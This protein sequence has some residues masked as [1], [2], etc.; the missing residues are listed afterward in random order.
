[1]KDKK[2][3]Q[4]TKLRDAKF[5]L[6]NLCKVKRK[7]PPGLIPFVLRECQK[8]LFNAIKVYSRI[9]IL[10]VRQL[11]FSTAVTGYFYHD[12]IMNPGTTTALIGYNTDM[13]AE[14]LDKVKTFYR[15]TPDDLKPTIHYNSKY[16]I[17]FPRIDSKILVLPSTESVGRGYTLNNCLCTELAM[18]DK[19]EE[20][21]TTLEASVPINGNL[22]IESTPGNIGDLYHRT[23]MNAKDISEN[24]DVNDYV[25][26][27]YGWWWGYSK[28]EIDIIE[29]RMNDP[30]R[31]A[32]EF[33]LEFM[34]SGRPVFDLKIV[35]EHRKNVLKVGHVV[36]DHVVKEIDGLRIYKK[37]EPGGVYVVGADTSEGVEGG[38]YSIAVILDRKT[39]EEVAFFRG[40]IPPDRFA[41]KLNKWGREYNNA[42][43]VVE[44]NNHGLTVITVLRQ[45]IYPTLYFR[46]AKFETMGQQISDRIGW[47]TNKVTRPLLID[48]LA[49]AMRDK[50]LIIHSKEILDEMMTFVYDDNGNMVC[51]SG[52]FDDTIFATG[53]A[54]QGFKVLFA[55]KLDQLDY[56]K[57]MPIS[58][59]Y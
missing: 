25:R 44:I 45:L 12:T 46:Q 35:N 32:R 53:I 36:G 28:E 23:Y 7:S 24:P 10:K 3:E 11:G 4:L 16:E 42:L 6:E 29:R 18:W 33:G 54:L 41:E 30:R 52:Y 9:I 21:M 38:D 59:G 40:L 2:I 5:Y 43:M 22:V 17:S 39:G 47:K 13:T 49:Q 37:P 48:D 14:L 34:S 57:H 8:D 51:L 31:F 27:E 56:S 20:K 55:G 50:T 58:F 19:A 15:T 1:M 26:K